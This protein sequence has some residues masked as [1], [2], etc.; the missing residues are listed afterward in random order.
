MVH[1]LRDGSI[2]EAQF[3]QVFDQDVSQQDAYDSISDG[4]EAV[5]KG[6]N[7]TIFAYGQ[8]GTGKTY[9]ILGG[10]F[11][12]KESVAAAR[13]DPSSS[14]SVGKNELPQYAGII[15]RAADELFH[16]AQQSFP[17]D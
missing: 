9:T 7:S 11:T 1:L 4:V 5:T 6:Y 10:S 8:T 3:D 16:F 15:P 14:K 13:D 2:V 12:G 17:T